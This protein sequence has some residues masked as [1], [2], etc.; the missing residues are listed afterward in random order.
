MG[1]NHLFLLL[2]SG[3]NF[4]ERVRNCIKCYVSRHKKSKGLIRKVSDLFSLFFNIKHGKLAH[5]L[6]ISSDFWS[7]FFCFEFVCDIKNKSQH[8]PNCEI[9]CDNKHDSYLRVR[10]KTRSKFL[11]RNEIN[12][13][14]P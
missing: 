14:N 3:T 4:F 5:I 1:D 11:T 7:F 10:W 13:H 12:L 9:T 6:S 8:E 2:Y